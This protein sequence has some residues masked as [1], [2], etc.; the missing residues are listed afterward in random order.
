MNTQF[1]NMTSG[2]DMNIH[3]KTGNGCEEGQDICGSFDQETF[4]KAHEQ[5]CVGFTGRCIR[6]PQYKFCDKRI[7]TFDGMWPKSTELSPEK[8]AEAGFFHTGEKDILCCFYCGVRV[9]EWE[10]KDCPFEEHF[11]W[12]PFC[13]YMEMIKVSKWT[14]TNFY[15]CM[16]EMKYI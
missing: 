5:F 14:K 12:S 1:D 10:N 16:N 6:Y 11:Y 8:L 15:K 2:N 9:R 13:D 3:E 7:W 4:S